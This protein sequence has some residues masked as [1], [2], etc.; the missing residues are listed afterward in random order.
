MTDPVPAMLPFRANQIVPAD[1]R[2]EACDGAV[3]NPRPMIERGGGRTYSGVCTAGQVIE[4]RVL[5]D[6]FGRAPGA[7]KQAV[8]F[9]V[10]QRFLKPE[11]VA[12]RRRSTEMAGATKKRDSRKSVR[13]PGWITLEGG[14]AARQCV[15]QDLLDIRRHDHGGRS[16]RAACQV[17]AGICARRAGPGETAKW[18]GAAA[19]RSASSSSGSLTASHAVKDRMRNILLA[20]TLAMW[21]ATTAM[22]EATRSQKSRQTRDFRPAASVEGRRRR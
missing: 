22:A 15:V 13:Q 17:A 14:F 1:Q 4:D 19:S 11:G 2:V 8:L 7:A 6:K 9:I 5:A 21:P 18:S 20:I 3:P 16:R 10:W 12:M